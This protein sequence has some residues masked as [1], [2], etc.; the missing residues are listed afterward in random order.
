MVFT[1]TGKRKQKK[2]KGFTSK[3]EVENTLKKLL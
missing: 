1:L 3:K 2:K